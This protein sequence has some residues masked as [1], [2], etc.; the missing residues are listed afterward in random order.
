[1]ENKN[2]TKIENI[3]CAKIGCGK[4]LSEQELFD[5]T[6]KR[7]MPLCSEHM[8]WFTTQMSKCAPLFTKI[9]A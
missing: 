7:T 4:I 2:I 9:N 5:S 3:K 1:M 6:K 8:E